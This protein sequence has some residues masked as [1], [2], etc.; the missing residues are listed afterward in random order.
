MMGMSWLAQ[1]CVICMC[2]HTSSCKRDSCIV[3]LQEGAGHAVMSAYV[4]VVF[5]NSDGRFPVRV[6]GLQWS[7]PCAKPWG[8]T[9]CTCYDRSA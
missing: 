5:D 1:E 2:D 8:V 6:T 3:C 9:L 7:L 4:E